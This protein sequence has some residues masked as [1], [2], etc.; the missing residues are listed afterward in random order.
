MVPTIS[1]PAVGA[2]IQ[3]DV[4]RLSTS[5]HAS[6]RYVVTEID[7]AE[8]IA[9]RPIVG[10]APGARSAHLFWW[11]TTPTGG[12]YRWAIVLSCGSGGAIPQLYAGEQRRFSRHRRPI[13]MTIEV[14]QTGL[15]A[16][17][18][19][20]EDISL[21]G[22]RAAVPVAIRLITAPSSRYAGRRSIHRL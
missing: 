20:T 14:P 10:C 21:G 19:I 7:G 1:T 17:D 12:A 4:P 6:G 18:G 22:L 3:I 2:R 8:A 16:V 15:G 5:L 11:A 13:A 9:V